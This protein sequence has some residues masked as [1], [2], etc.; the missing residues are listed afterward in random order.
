MP[1]T[2]AFDRLTSRT[3]SPGIREVSSAWGCSYL[4]FILILTGGA[5][6]PRDFL[7]HCHVGGTTLC[8]YSGGTTNR[9]WDSIGP[10]HH[11]YLSMFLFSFALSEVGCWATGADGSDNL[12]CAKPVGSCSHYG[13]DLKLPATGSDVQNSSARWSG[14]AL[15]VRKN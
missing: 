3:L 11:R 13:T 14:Q 10:C 12:R 8:H 15:S 5:F 9:S 4:T 7:P 1:C 2:P 6:G